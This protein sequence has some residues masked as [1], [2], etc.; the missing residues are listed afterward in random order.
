MH[1]L[2]Q[3]PTFCSLLNTSVYHYHYWNLVLFVG[4]HDTCCLGNWSHFPGRN[5]LCPRHSM[6]T[7]PYRSWN[8]NWSPHI[9]KSHPH[10]HHRFYIWWLR[11]SFLSAFARYSIKLRPIDL[12]IWH[13]L[14]SRL[15]HE[16][17]RNELMEANINPVSQKC[18]VWEC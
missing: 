12:C 4:R 6:L 9:Y 17:D 11:G 7:F 14:D 3:L 15:R 5:F 1:I 2:V 18:L 13:L 10:L 8:C 16:M